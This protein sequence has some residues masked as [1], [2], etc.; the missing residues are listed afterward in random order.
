MLLKYLVSAG[1]KSMQRHK[2]GDY[3]MVIGL[4]VQMW[5]DNRLLSKISMIFAFIK[6]LVSVI[7]CGYIFTLSI[8]CNVQIKMQM[9]R[10][11]NKIKEI[12]Y[13]KSSK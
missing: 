6:I 3:Q 13:G 4:C 7:D 2:H 8:A 5:N 12:Y 10:E 11:K 1:I 9:L